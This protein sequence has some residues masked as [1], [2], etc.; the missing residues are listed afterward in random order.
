MQ[1]APRSAA[2]WPAKGLSSSFSSAHASSRAPF[3]CASCRLQQHQQSHVANRRQ[4]RSFASK[5]SPSTPPAPPPSS[6]H[7]RLRTRRLIS[8]SGVDAPH[9][10][11]GLVTTS[12]EGN[13]TANPNRS[14]KPTEQAPWFYCGFLNA[15]GRVLHDVFVYPAPPGSTGEPHFIIEVDTAQLATLL[16]HLKRY[17]LR[18]KISLRA[19]EE[20]EMSV[21]QIWNDADMILPTQEL[22]GPV[23]KDERSIM[24]PDFRAPGMG[25]RV[26]TYGVD[27]D[28]P[29]LG[30]SSGLQSAAGQETDESAY[31]VHRYLRGVPEGSAEIIPTQA[32]P[33]ESNMDIMGGIDFRKGCY[34]GQELTIRTR[35]RGVVRKRILPCMLYSESDA[36]PKSLEFRQG[37]V[38]PVVSEARD[39]HGLTI[40]RHGKKGRSTGTFLAG[41]GNIGLALCRVQL[42]TDLVVPNDTATLEFDPT[43]E[44]VMQPAKGGE[45]EAEAEA[46]TGDKGVVKVKAFVPEWLRR[47]LDEEVVNQQHQQAPNAM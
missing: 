42:M 13:S 46:E 18:S 22:G 41:T 44:F 8:I 33:Q 21:W 28:V 24:I 19:L 1:A 38:P 30:L 31:R 14:T 37:A 34:V 7:A 15:L 3:V 20:D 9:F 5:P 27:L 43:A 23:R 2:R 6:G 40:G 36:V 17:K 16:K 32:L 4:R 45:G 39:L 10:L 47:R 35:H 25:Y 12:I 29:A 11:Q 26:L